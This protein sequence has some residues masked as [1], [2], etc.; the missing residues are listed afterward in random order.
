MSTPEQPSLAETVIGA[1]LSE[2][3]VGTPTP[4]QRIE[5][6]ILE[7]FDVVPKVGD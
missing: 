3:T 2:L 7:H 5:A 1:I 4:Q 6:K